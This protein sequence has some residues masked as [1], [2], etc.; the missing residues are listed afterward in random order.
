MHKAIIAV[1]FLFA[2]LQAGFLTEA[3]GDFYQDASSLS[4]L[5]SEIA[6]QVKQQLI[7]RQQNDCSACQAGSTA[8]EC[9]GCQTLHVV[10]TCHGCAATHTCETCYHT[11]CG[12]CEH[13]ASCGW[14]Y[15]HHC[16]TCESEG[17]CESECL[18]Y[19]AKMRNMVLA[20]LN[21]KSQNTLGSQ[22]IKQQIAAEVENA[23]ARRGIVQGNN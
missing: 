2:T 14:C 9:S 23:L 19:L 22:G 8:A 3:S 10:D 5:K 20:V 7:A 18:V 11:E 12:K 21:G 13:S 17:Q 6:S 16:D 4:D 15:H 1:A